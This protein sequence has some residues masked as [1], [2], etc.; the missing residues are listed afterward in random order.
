MA[1]AILELLDSDDAR[2]K[3]RID[4]GTNGY[5]Q[6]K[7]GK[8]VTRRQGIDWIDGVA[9]GTDIRRNEAGGSLLSSAKEISIPARTFDDGNAYIQLF[10][11]KTPDGKSPAFSQV[12][13]AGLRYRYPF[14]NKPVS[15]LSLANATSVS[16]TPMQANG[17][18][19]T[20]RSVPCRT[21][22][23]VYS[24]QASLED[25][26]GSVV[27]FLGPVVSKLL[28]AGPAGQTGG[29]AA[30]GAA[31]PDLLKGGVEALANLLKN[32]LGGVQG[33]AQAT[34][35]R[36]QSVFTETS[37]PNRFFES[38]SAQFA[39]PF[40]FGID[41]ALV[42]AAI[43]QIVQIL[44][45]LMNGANQHR[46]QMQQE[47]NKLTTDALNGINARLLQDKL[48]EAQQQAAK[49][50]QTAKAA[51]LEQLIKLLQV[52]AETGQTA[53]NLP[54]IA[55]PQSLA[56][57]NGYSAALSNKAVLS[58]V[59]A[60]L[61]SWNGKPSILFVKGQPLQLKIQFTVAE[62]APKTPLPKAILKITFKDHANQSVLFE[63]TFKQKDVAPNS[64]MKFTFAEGELAHLPANKPICLLAEIRWLRSRDRKEISAFGGSEM[65]IVTKHFVKEQGETLAE[66]KELADMNRFRPFWNKIWEAPTLDK[67]AQS[68]DGKKYLWELDVNAKYSVMLSPDHE[69]NGLMNTRVLQGRND[70]DSLSEKTEGRIKS[71]I[72]LSVA[73]LNKLLP[74]WGGAALET[75]KLEAFKTESFAKDNTREFVYRLK[76]KGKAADRGMVWVIPTFKLTEFTLGSAVKTTEDGQVME[77][78][79]EKVRFPLPVAARV[80]GL[81]SN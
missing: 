49:D 51:E 35:A 55:K 24:Q 14:Q 60:D 70:Q 81:K 33:G 38:P 54:P 19:Q 10:T 62:P 18:F 52:Q 53:A 2:V 25:V 46:Q 56:S 65:T 71:G 66:E 64:V 80:I 67:A 13:R 73:E 36:T 72:E 68:G 41:D 27:Q 76:L 77:I 8:S 11:Y 69:A 17:S 63:K 31:S 34:T 58:F 3:F 5:Y 32:L 45:Q 30:G 9:G 20:P 42:G 79:E 48:L 47:H 12:S 37:K 61:V 29:S 16:A 75:D 78:S 28:T 50:A 44:P 59:T 15:E 26:L 4:T 22:G 40:V 1:L 7:I 21:Y 57:Q 74:L 23:E 43:G 6:L 39:R